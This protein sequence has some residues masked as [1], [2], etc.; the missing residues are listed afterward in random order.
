M[1]MVNNGS[2]DEQNDIKQNS[3]EV[4]ADIDFKFI[5]RSDFTSIYKSVQRRRRDDLE[6]KKWE[7]FLAKKVEEE[8]KISYLKHLGK[9]RSLGHCAACLQATCNLPTPKTENLSCQ[10]FKHNYDPEELM[11]S[12]PNEASN[13]RPT[14]ANENIGYNVVQNEDREKWKVMFP[15][16]TSPNRE[17]QNEYDSDPERV[18]GPPTNSNSSSLQECD[19]LAMEFDLRKVEAFRSKMRSTLQKIHKL[20]VQGPVMSEKEDH[21][22]I[23]QRSSEF[24]A[25]FKRNYLYRVQCNINEIDKLLK[26]KQKSAP[27]ELLTQKIALGHQACV[28]TLQVIEKHLPTITVESPFNLFNEFFICICDLTYK[29]KAAFGLDSKKVADDI[30]DLSENIMDSMVDL[31][32]V[33]QPTRK[34]KVK[35]EKKKVKND[36]WMYSSKNSWLNKAA[37]LAKSKFGQK[38]PIGTKITANTA[39]DKLQYLA[40]NKSSKLNVR[41]RDKVVDENEI[42]TMVEMTDLNE[43]DDDSL[44]NDDL[45]IDVNPTFD[46][47]IS[48]DQQASKLPTE[49][50]PTVS[51]R[52]P[53]T[54]QSPAVDIQ[55]SSNKLVYKNCHPKKCDKTRADKKNVALICLKSDMPEDKRKCRWMGDERRCP[56]K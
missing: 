26:D 10:Q 13:H 15:R 43:T 7:L 40:A 2:C 35:G 50:K 36:L 31:V 51:S 42:K 8:R 1:H 46:Q 9:N 52:I 22:R 5:S 27:R 45:R 18:I 54:A 20:I 48:I 39:V 4:T 3:S 17:T 25:R 55:V 24:S 53:V 12:F 29:F 11:E 6:K 23:R 37:S 41:K 56:Q 19:Q 16:N 28:Q 33:K 44:C 38:H 30:V 14:S 49:R 32:K 21:D 34:A 47:A